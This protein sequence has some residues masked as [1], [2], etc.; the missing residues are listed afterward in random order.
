MD[1]KDI[2][3]NLKFNYSQMQ[4]IRQGLEKGLDISQYA[5]PKFHWK[6]MQGI[7]LGLKENIEEILEGRELEDIKF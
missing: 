2:I 4:E 1:N 3:K 6:Q 7:R 5:D